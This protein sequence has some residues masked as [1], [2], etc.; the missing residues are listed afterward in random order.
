MP[1]KRGPD[2]VPVDIPS[3]NPPWEDIN[4]SPRKP[5]AGDIPTDPPRGVVFPD[6]PVTQHSKSRRRDEITDPP[7]EETHIG[8]RPLPHRVRDRITDPPHK[9]TVLRGAARG[10]DAGMDDPVAGWLVIVAGKGSGNFV[11]IGHGQNSIGRGPDSRA[12]L[13]YGDN[14]ISRS[15]HAVITYDALGR[16]FYVQQGDG[17]NLTY[18]DDKPVLAPTVLENGSEITMGQ[19]RLRFVALCGP[20][21]SWP[22]A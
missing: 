18:L 8:G 4:R 16:M 5:G 19:T 12:Q 17:K 10:A 15:R 20:D 9:K 2:G 3:V 11:K 1:K 22:E 13:D 14:H 7:N 6:E 21:F